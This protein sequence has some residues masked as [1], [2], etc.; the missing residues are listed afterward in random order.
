MNIRTLI[1]V[2]S[3]LIPLDRSIETQRKRDKKEEIKNQIKL[4]KK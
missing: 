4:E 3:V 2:S 1:N